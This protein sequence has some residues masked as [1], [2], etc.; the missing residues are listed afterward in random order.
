MRLATIDIGS[1]A[2]RLLIVDATV[3]RQRVTEFNKLNFVRLPLRL[4]FD[5]FETGEIGKEKTLLFMNAMKVFKDIITFYEV[6]FVKACATSA[7]RDARNSHELVERAKR[8]TGL[9]IEVISGDQEA[10]IVHDTHIAE[11]MDTEHGYLYMNV[12]GGSTDVIFYADGKMRYKKSFD[13]GTIRLVKN[14]INDSMWAKIKSDLKT[15]IKCHLPL[16]AIGSGGNINTVFSLSKKKEGKPLS[17]DLLREYYETFSA[18][19]VEER[20]HDYGMREDRAVVIVPALQIFINMMRWTNIKSMYVPKI[21][22]VDG[23][24]REL[25]QEVVNKQLR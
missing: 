9:D 4:G 22:V 14:Q 1:N 3:N 11:N 10:I 2:A 6:K 8:E 7:M 12:G 20:M 5:V 21:G 13:V 15:H 18:L 17:L 16:V 23:L 19:S 24:A 25:Y